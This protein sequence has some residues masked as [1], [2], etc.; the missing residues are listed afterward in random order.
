VASLLPVGVSK[1][2]HSCGEQKIAPPPGAKVRAAPFFVLL[3]KAVER[4]E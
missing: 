1:G 2:R 4:R 3:R